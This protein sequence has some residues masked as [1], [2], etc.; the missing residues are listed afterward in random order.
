MD[1]AMEVGEKDG[2]MNERISVSLLF[3]DTRDAVYHNELLGFVL[4]VFLFSL[5]EYSTT[6]KTGEG[7]LVYT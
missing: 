3:L 7:L 1:E 6:E 4:V 2:G 5:V